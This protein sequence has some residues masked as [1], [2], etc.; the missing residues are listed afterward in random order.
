MLKLQSLLGI[1]A[2]LAFAWLIS[3]NRRA[4]SWKHVGIGLAL[5]I[6][7]AALFLKLPPLRALFA[8]AN[9]AVVAIGDASRAGTSFVFGYLG[10]G[11]LPFELKSP[12]AE[13]VLAFQ[14][15]PIVLLMSV[16]TTLLFYWRVLPPVVRGFSWALERT[17]GVGGAVGLSSA[18]NIFVGH[19]EAPLFIRPYLAQLSRGELFIVMTGGMAGIAGTVLVLYTQFLSTSVPDAAGHFIIAS[20]LSAPLA[21]L[22]GQIMMPDGGK[23]TGSLADPEPVADSTMDAIAKGTAAGLALLLNMI[24][25]L[26]VFVALVHLVNAMLGRAARVRRRA[27]HAAARAR[28]DHGAGHLADR[29][30]MGAG[31]DRGLADGHQDHPQ[32]ADRLSRNVKAAGRRARCALAADHALR[33]VR[34]RQLR[35]PRHHDRRLE[36]DGAGAPR[37]RARAGIEVDRVGH[38]DDAADGRDRG[39]AALVNAAS[40]VVVPAR[41]GDP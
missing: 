1:A 19:V 35:Q 8:A 41:A 30:S 3:E 12:G 6:A 32:R 37:R 13:F 27:G 10:G 23:P 40:S 38:A 22:I 7:L 36:R 17:L 15:L 29:H 16:L 2:I 28:M 5:S 34:L 14:A 24:A 4:V 11:P 26:I 31:A 18:A 39:A 25:M 9:S 20:V 21:V 33:D